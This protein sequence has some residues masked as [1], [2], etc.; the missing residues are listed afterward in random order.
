M[1]KHQTWMDDIK[2]QME[3]Q[4]GTLELIKLNATSEIADKVKAE[5]KLLETRARALKLVLGYDDG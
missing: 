2:V 3:S 5:M 4:R 1:N